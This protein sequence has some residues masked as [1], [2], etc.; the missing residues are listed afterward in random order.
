VDPQPFARAGDVLVFQALLDE[1]ERIRASLAALVTR[2]HELGGDAACRSGLFRACGRALAEVADA[3]ADGRDPRGAAQIWEPLD[4]CARTLPRSVL[5]D[6]LLGQ[7]RAAWRMAGVLSADTRVPVRGE[8]LPPLRRRP[9]IRDAVMTLRANLT[10]QS[11]ACRHALRVAA[12]VAIGTA[13][14]RLLALPRGYWIPM[15]AL[16]VLKPEFHDTFIRGVARMAGT[17]AGVGLAAAVVH[18][19]TPGRGALTMLVLASVWGCYAL[20]RINYAMFTVCLTAYVVFI[21]MLSGVAEATAAAL[22]AEYTVAGGLLALLLYAVWP[23]WAGATAR[24][25]LAAMLTAHSRYVRALLDAFADPSRVDLA[26][27]NAIRADAR[28]ARSNAEAVVERM[29]AEPTRRAALT[30]RVTIG[31]LAALR[32]HALAALAL[33]AGLERGVRAPVPG[34][35]LLA[36]E[37]TAAL[38]TLAASMEAGTPPPPLQNLRATQL[39]LG[40]TDALVNDETDL[41]VD[42]VNTIGSLLKT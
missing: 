3:L 28:L 40:A 41:M 24:A 37:M 2:Q 16:I 15:T 19:F 39:A 12:A 14:A 4:A 32:R 23:T 17:I 10:L 33:H 7:V 21:L 25:A 6:A 26:R 36:D 31:V 22:R 9:P 35:A 38:A 5:I 1:A 11:A 34:M 13:G 42:S 30:P 27:I 29:L 18:A 20:F 8:R